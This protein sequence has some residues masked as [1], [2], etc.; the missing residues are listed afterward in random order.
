M[1]YICASF[2]TEVCDI[3]AGK[4]G[5][6]LREDVREIC[7]VIDTKRNPAEFRKGCF[8]CCFHFGRNSPLKDCALYYFPPTEETKSLIA[9]CNESNR[10]TS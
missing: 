8:H 1:Q 9:K 7:I 4:Q 3:A 5:I 2:E 10:S 6:I